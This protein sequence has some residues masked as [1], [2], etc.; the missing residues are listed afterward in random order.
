MKINFKVNLV[1]VAILLFGGIALGTGVHFL[2]A[3]QV[4]ANA[5]SLLAQA[6]EAEEEKEFRKAANYLGQYLGLVPTNNKAE[7]ARYGVLLDD[8]AKSP[9]DRMRPFFLL[10]Q[11]LRQDD[12]NTDVRRRVVQIALAIGRFNDA[13]EHLKILTAA[14]LV[15]A[16]ILHGQALCEV[17]EGHYAEAATFY[18]KAVELAPAQA[19]LCLEYAKLL[20]LHLDSTPLATEVVTKM[21]AAGP[22][23][24]KVRLGAARYY[25]SIGEHDLAEKSVLFALNELKVQEPEAYLLAAKV[26]RSKGQKAI[27]KAHLEHGRE[28]NPDEGRLSLALA[29]QEFEAGR[30]EEALR[31]VRPSVAKLPDSEV[32]LWLLC[33]LLIDLGK[34]LRLNRLPYFLLKIKRFSSSSST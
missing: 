13:R 29:R 11:V 34:V 16:E 28:A 32:E 33:K 8:M 4:R 3:Y 23:S 26:A 14:G 20:R 21:V 6:D 19:D 1:A 30:R 27:A 5:R 15:D 10:E 17:G 18:A 31:L 22:R 9:R 25:Q 2:H 24:A 7:L 12:S